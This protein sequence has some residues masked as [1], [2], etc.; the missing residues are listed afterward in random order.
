M[1]VEFYDL[2]QRLHAARTGQP[3]PRLLHSPVPSIARPLAVRARQQ[4]PSVLVTAACPGSP[5]VTARDHDA[6]TALGDLGVRVTADTWQTLLTD[7]PATLPALLH[8]ARRADP[9]S[10]AGQVAAHIAW[11]ANRTD[12]PGSSAV[13]QL[14]PG[15]RARWVTGTVPQ[16]EQQPVTWRTWLQVADDGCAGLLNLLDRL[17]DAP[18]LALLDTVAEDD[19]WSWGRAQS[20]H[21]DG[22]DWRR[23]DTT[24]RAAV[25]LRARCDAADLYAA[26]LLSDPIYRRR[27]VHTGHAVLGQACQPS[28]GRNRLS[29]LCE[30]MDARLR[31]GNTVT[32]WTGAPGDSTTD[33]FHGTVSTTGMHDGRLL[34]TLTGV[35]SHR[36]VEH[37]TV[38][39]I[40]A[41]PST[42]TMRAGRQRYARLYGARRS[43]LTTGRTPTPTRRDVPLEVLIAGAEDD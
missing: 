25:G 22:W 10:P 7:D 9:D 19:A 29:V 11:W 43:W 20:E 13:V 32:G 24:G 15:C 14:L 35:T 26:A 27:A 5:P 31:T 34:L 38:T 1:S 4:G 16:A 21:T 6:L 30:R 18:P 28:T 42:G 37:A 12:F 36:P 2:A 33:R 3:V 39:L 41:A 40:P 17:T 8:L 23:P